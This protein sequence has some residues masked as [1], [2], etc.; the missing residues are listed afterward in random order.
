MTDTVDRSTMTSNT[1]VE[2][3]MAATMSTGAMREVQEDVARAE[4]TTG[5]ATKG[6]LRS[7]KSVFQVNAK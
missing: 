2:D 6:L 7:Q 4:I 1:R 5:A 3:N